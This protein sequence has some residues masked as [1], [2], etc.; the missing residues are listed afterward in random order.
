VDY[1]H[2]HDRF[3]T[4]L[5]KARAR[6]LIDIKLE[7]IFKRLIEVGNLAAHFGPISDKIMEGGDTLGW[8]VGELDAKSALKDAVELLNALSPRLP[9]TGPIFTVTVDP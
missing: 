4:L 1:S 2:V 6:K 3:T 5:K 9:E 7:R 8:S